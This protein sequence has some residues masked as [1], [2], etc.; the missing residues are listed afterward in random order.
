L[1]GSAKKHAETLSLTFEIGVNT[2]R[3]DTTM[4]FILVLKSWAKT[5][6]SYVKE[7]SSFYWRLLTNRVGLP[8]WLWID[9]LVFWMIIVFSIVNHNIFM[10]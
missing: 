2:N 3:K 4:V 7:A 5:V 8:K 1:G 6:W 9:M 10:Y